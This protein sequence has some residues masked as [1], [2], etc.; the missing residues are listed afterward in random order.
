MRSII[1]PGPSIQAMNEP[2]PNCR[3]PDMH[4][5][6]S[7]YAILAGTGSLARGIRIALLVAALG[8]SHSGFAQAA[9]A[10]APTPA[11]STTSAADP[12]D[13][14]IVF[15]RAERQIGVAV[16]ASEGTVGG[17][18]LLVRPMLKV[19]ELL[20][21]VPGLIAAQ[22]S[23]SG[24]A[25]QYFLRG[26]N[27]DH[28]T[29]FTTYIDDVPMNLRTHGHGQGYLD[30]N[31]LISE[32][33]E[34]VDFR[35]GTYRADTGDFSPAGAAFMST[36]DRYDAP[37]VAA[38]GGQF[39]W[40]R[41]AAGGT[42]MVGDGSLTYVAQYQGYDGPWE[43][44]ED[45]QHQSGWLK[46]AKPLD[47]ATL[48][49]SLSGYHATWKP[50]E[51]IPERVIGSSVCEDAFCSLDPTA[52]GETTRWIATARLLG[53]GWRA[54]LYGQ[55]YD[56]HMVSDSTYDN[57]V[58]Q[59][60][61]RWIAGGRYEREWLIGTA[62]ALT[63]GTEFRYDD[64]GRVGL[65]HTDRGQFVEW[66]GVHAV[67]EGSVSAYAEGHWNPTEPLRL[68][69]G[70]RADYF[71]FQVR[72]RID[73][74][75]QYGGNTSASRV[76]PKLGAAYKLSDTVE[77]YAN[78]GRGFHSNDA[79]GVVNPITPAPGLSPS[80]GKEG[81]IRFEIGGAKLTATYWWL[82][83]DSEL[84]FVGDSNSV[85][86]GAATARRGYELTGFWRPIPTIAIDG[87]WTGSRGRY[88]D[89]PGAEYISGAVENAGELG[90]AFIDGPWELSAR[91][92]YLGGYPLIEDNSQRADPEVHVNLRAAW[93][94][95][96]WNLYGEVLN[97]LGDNAK[98]IT[99]WYESFVAGFDTVPTEGR[100]SRQ[101]E[102]RTLRVG[103]RY[104]F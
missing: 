6:S 73:L 79:R 84:K 78:W 94:P 101:E 88:L 103:L 19:A 21:A 85:E 55:Y 23:G 57:Q 17:D 61:R 67:K 54:T 5:D 47:F 82:D 93:K 12:M 38:E 11:P 66:V 45:L 80:V 9:T 29:D 24:K 86:P 71:D 96:S 44:P 14:I 49:L 87:V 62:A 1:D 36:I 51:Q 26:F 41:L 75:D 15:G 70:L 27:L 13:E 48:N 98:D 35:K 28:G 3:Y 65:Q 63:A 76:S 32:T 46:F 99:Y 81:G 58:N 16:T 64:I 50:T 7:R 83:L 18:D 34:R 100:M 8:A 92:R 53:Q 72:E 4:P 22:H 89:S 33:V 91:M 2:D 25:N 68:S 95:G 30:V 90:V 69:A 74:P 39:G 97:V 104:N 40:R 10:P 59:L 31:G 37:F 52:V 77:L 102:P 42:S 56:W 43:L 20:E 60:D